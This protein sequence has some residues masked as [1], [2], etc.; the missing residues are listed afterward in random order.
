MDEKVIKEDKNKAR[1]LVSKGGVFEDEYTTDYEKSLSKKEET[2]ESEDEIVV[3]IPEHKTEVVES[4]GKSEDEI[5]KN[6]QSIIKARKEHEKKVAEKTSALLK[7]G[8]GY[9]KDGDFENAEESFYQMMIT[10]PKNYRGYFGIV[11]AVTH[12]FNQFD[13]FKDVEDVY[14]KAVSLYDDNAKKELAEKYLKSFEKSVAQNEKDI[15][16]FDEV[17]NKSKE[18]RIEKCKI[19]NKKA[20]SKLWKVAIPFVLGLV[21]CIVGI[22]LAYKF[23]ATKSLVWVIISSVSGAV[24]GVSF[25]LIL[26]CISKIVTAF[27]FKHRAKTSALTEEGEKSIQLKKKNSYLNRIIEDIK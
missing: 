22:S 1:K 11:E 25:I 18:E 26:T 13:E 9:L 15:K 12:N 7:E 16:T 6:Q 24:A 3:E 5:I 23:T 4:V 20:L 27:T 8:E 19:L 17:E 2:N 21:L 10:N 14:T